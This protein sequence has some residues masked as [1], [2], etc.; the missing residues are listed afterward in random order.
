MDD[1]NLSGKKKTLSEK[2]KS[3]CLRTH[4]NMPALNLTDETPAG[5]IGRA[6]MAELAKEDAEAE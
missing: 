5:M 2:L 4:A 6:L 1:R 3:I